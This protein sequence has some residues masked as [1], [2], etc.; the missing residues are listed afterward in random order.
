MAIIEGQN[1]SLFHKDGLWVISNER[2]EIMKSYNVD[3]MATGLNV[4]SSGTSNQ[5]QLSPLDLDAI[6]SCDDY[7]GAIVCSLKKKVL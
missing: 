3:F 6:I 7:S 1:L 5:L 2:G 4:A